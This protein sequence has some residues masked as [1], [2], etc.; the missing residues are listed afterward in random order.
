MEGM[1]GFPAEQED[2]AIA[3][4]ILRRVE[5]TADFGFGPV[6]AAFV[7]FSPKGISFG[8]PYDVLI[9]EG[10]PEDVSPTF[11]VQERQRVTV[12]ADGS[13]KIHLPGVSPDL[14]GFDQSQ[15]P[16]AQWDSLCCWSFTL[17]WH[18][19]SMQPLQQWPANPK[20]P[21][22]PSRCL[23][24]PVSFEPDAFSSVVQ[25]CVVNPRLRINDLAVV[26]PGNG[27]LWCLTGGWPWVLVRMS[28]VMDPGVVELNTVGRDYR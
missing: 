22:T 26:V 1:Q 27:P 3:H 8:V 14:K 18:P 10:T 17:D 11:A 25:I 19:D 16:L 28:N 23:N 12:H 2:V 7:D 20:P 6:Q 15:Q 13:V 5:F 4:Q 21:T 9:H 24:I